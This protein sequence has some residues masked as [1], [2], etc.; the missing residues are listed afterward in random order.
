MRVIGCRGLRLELVVGLGIAMAMPALAAEN[1]RSLATQTRL[2]AETRDQGGRTQ[3]TLAVTVAG[4][5]G[6]PAAG[7]VAIKDFGREIAGSVLNAEGKARLALDL[8]GGDHLLR[9]VYTGDAGHK[10]SLSTLTGVHALNTGVPDFQIS[11]APATLSLTAGQSGIVIASVTPENANALTGPVFVTLSCS[12]NP[13]QSSCTFTP[14]S[15]EILQNAVNPVNSSM[16][17]QTQ[18]AGSTG[19]STPPAH[20][21]ARPIAWAFLLP[22]ALGLVGLA[23]GGRRRRWLSRLSLL[24]LVALVTTLGTTGCNPLYYYEHHGPPTNP[25][26]PSGSYIVKVTAQS[27][28]GV[29]AITHSTTLALTVK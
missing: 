9:A 26:T 2:A 7:T 8:P 5:D 6:L 10:A 16:V 29:T 22:G 20:P 27:T 1:A 18:A 4:E 28:N 11:I 25:A 3:A 14:G 19:L 12:G 24:A 17:F 15:V 23:W 21:G 13:D